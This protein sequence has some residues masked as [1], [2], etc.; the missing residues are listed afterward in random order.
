MTP[1]ERAD[2]KAAIDTAL[3]LA[4]KA[5]KQVGPKVHNYSGYSNGCHCQ[6]CTEAWRLYKRARYRA[7]RDM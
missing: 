6:I 2:L 7:R 4:A 3:R 5:E 1:Q